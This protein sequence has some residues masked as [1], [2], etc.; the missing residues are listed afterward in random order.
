[1]S[2]QPL[3]V[4]LTAG[5]RGNSGRV[6]VTN[7]F[8]RP[9]PVEVKIYPLAMSDTGEISIGGP[10]TTD[11]QVFPP[12]AVIQPSR[13][14]AFRLQYRGDTSKL[15]SNYYIVSIAQ[16][17]VE[18]G[19]RQSGIQLLYN[20]QIMANVAPMRGAA[21]LNV[22]D[23]AVRTNDKGETRAR[24]T[25]SNTGPAHAYLAGL[26]LRFAFKNPQGR[27]LWD[28]TLDGAQLNAL[29][30]YGLIRHQNRRSFEIAI[31]PPPSALT[32]AFS[33]EILGNDGLR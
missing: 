3:I 4:D 28:R 14:Q 1:M 22:T 7:T 10:A 21:A 23:A 33:L 9:I 17:P 15:T 11:F 26:R 32:G 2:V 29:I 27:T 18:L 25:L 16:V 12:T 30:G 8:S 13:S 5:A 24:F 20:F 19:E 6:A 31:N